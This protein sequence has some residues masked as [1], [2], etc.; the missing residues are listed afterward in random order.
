MKGFI[1]SYWLLLT[2]LPATN[3]NC[4][5]GEKP[6]SQVQTNNTTTTTSSTNGTQKNPLDAV[7][8][9]NQK[10]TIHIYVCT[11]GCYQYVLETELDGKQYK[12]SPDVLDDAFK[13]DKLTVIFSGKTTDEFVDI[14]KPAPNDVPIL[15]F[16]A[17]K[18]LL[19]SIKVEL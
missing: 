14:K 6:D 10:G 15:D 12:L 8:F 18:V 3:M 2:V 17:P 5:K 19:E 13:K 1:L 7:I 4:S 16:K 11:R 9:T